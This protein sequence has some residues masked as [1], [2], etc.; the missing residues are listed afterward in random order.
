MSPRSSRNR[1]FDG[2]S[3]GKSSARRLSTWPMLR[4]GGPAGA[5]VRLCGSAL[6][7]AGCE[8]REVEAGGVEGEPELADLHL[9]AVGEQRRLD[10]D[11]VEEGAVQA[12]EVLDLERGAVAEEL[13][14]PPGDRDVVEEDVAR[15]VA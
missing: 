6:T 11:A 3:S 10:P 13:G 7:S 1:S 12:A 5:C 4:V 14:V 9:G 15:R 8:T 2:E